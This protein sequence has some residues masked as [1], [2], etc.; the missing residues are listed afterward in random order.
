[1]Q[2]AMSEVPCGVCNDS[3]R[4]GRRR[5]ARQIVI[6]HTRLP[7]AQPN[8]A[9]LAQAPKRTIRQP[10]IYSASPTKDLLDQAI[11]S[12]RCLMSESKYAEKSNNNP[13]LL[14]W[15]DSRSECISLEANIEKRTFHSK[16]VLFCS[17]A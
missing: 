3:M 9:P 2:Q 4:A 8:F 13:R 11:I 6:R 12:I 7:C 14:E 10:M 15:L 1:M 5:S 16:P 17:E